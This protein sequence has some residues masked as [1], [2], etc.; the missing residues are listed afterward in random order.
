MTL[1]TLQALIAIFFLISLLIIRLAYLQISKHELYTTLSTKNWLDL[2]PIEPTRGLIY[3]RHGVLLAENISVFSLDIIPY[4]VSNINHTLQELKKI[5]LLSDDELTQF[6]RQRRQHRRFDEIPLKLRLSEEEVLRFAEHQYRFPGIVIKARLMRHY[7]FNNSFSHVIGYV[8][9]INTQELN[10]IDETNYSASHYI[11][12]TGLEKYYE[13]EL[14][15]KVGY[16]EVETD[17]SGK[18]LRVLKNI[19]GIPGKNLHLTLDAKLQLAIE[20][21]LAGQRGA[22]VAIEPASGQVI[23]MVSEPSFNPNLFVSGISQKDYQALTT[24]PDRPLYN[25]AV[26]GLYPP[27]STIKPFLAL[28]GLDAGFIRP[29]DTI[30]DPGW[31]QLPNNSR[32]YNDWIHN[33]HGT[34]NVSR[35]IT[36]SCDVFFYRLATDMGIDH[37]DDILTEFGFGVPSGIDLDK[38]LSGTV[39]SPEWKR[40]VKGVSWYKG[41][42]VITGIGQGFMQVTPLQL[43]AATATLANRGHRVMPHLLLGTQMPNKPYQAKQPILQDQIVLEDEKTWNIIIKAMQAVVD[44]PQG[45]AYRFGLD[46]EYTLAGKTGTAQIIAKR[47]R[48]DERDAQTDIPDRLKDHHLFIAFA[49]VDHPQIALAIITENSNHAVKTA[50]K[51]FDFYLTQPSGTKRHV[52]RQPQTKTQKTAP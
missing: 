8:G 43:A 15:G 48:P 16:E 10:E 28:E 4:Q 12:K 23:A 26:H 47:G 17:A 3:D 46:R 33:G 19:K 51:I 27:A 49:P 2:V 36:S 41:D 38:E 6:Q 22:V 50:R 39:A 42:T 18:S 25:R 40:R 30:Y 5:I 52:D 24:S 9:R 1:R 37:I 21:A 14:H 35:A 29:N 34:V 31:F 32:R 44:S 45:T 20:S 13:D 7:P 11:G